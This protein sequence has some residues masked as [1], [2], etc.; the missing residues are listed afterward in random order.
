MYNITN[1]SQILTKDLFESNFASIV[2]RVK[3]NLIK[4]YPY[5]ANGNRFSG[6]N[7]DDYV[8]EG[9]EKLIKSFDFATYTY[10][11]EQIKLISF[12][13]MLFLASE[14]AVRYDNRSATSKKNG[15]ETK[16]SFNSI[17]IEMDGKVAISDKVES[18]LIES[19]LLNSKVVLEMQDELNKLLENAESNNDKKFYKRLQIFIEIETLVEEGISLADAIKIHCDYFPNTSNYY[20]FKS[21]LV[22]D[23]RAKK[24]RRIFAEMV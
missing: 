17:E 23:A 9:F 12:Q 8:G 15:K 18:K 19:D 5:L 14:Q 10:R 22:K 13:Y 11:N 16:F 4:R 3:S 1:G 2:A 6:K 20:V 7:V 24:L 21:S